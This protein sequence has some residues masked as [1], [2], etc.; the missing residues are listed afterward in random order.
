LTRKRWNS[1]LRA[2]RRPSGKGAKKEPRKAALKVKQGEKSD[3]FSR[4]DRLNPEALDNN[5]YT[6]GRLINSIDPV[7]FRYGKSKWDRL[8][9]PPI[10]EAAGAV[11]PVDSMGFS[12]CLPLQFGAILI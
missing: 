11:A 4:R 5:S 10:G 6:P 2:S 7:C 8:A 12:V 1:R 3:H 9:G